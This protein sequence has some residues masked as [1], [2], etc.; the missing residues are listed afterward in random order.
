MK[1][2]FISFSLPR[3]CQ[4]KRQRLWC[5][6][7]KEDVKKKGKTEEA[8]RHKGTDFETDLLTVGPSG[9][10]GPSTNIPWNTKAQI[11]V[12]RRNQH[13]YV[14]SLFVS[15][16][17]QTHT[18]LVTKS[19]IHE[20]LSLHIMFPSLQTRHTCMVCLQGQGHP[21]VLPYLDKL[22]ARANK[23]C[24]RTK[25]PT[26]ETDLQMHECSSAAT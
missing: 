19:E 14:R 10:G 21:E 7:G 13:N 24:V 8:K 2:S 9:P 6:E 17:L 3:G 25:T 12:Y 5:T 23:L 15:T 4:E 11:I 22:I 20:N 16:W 18:E 26:Q 1:Q